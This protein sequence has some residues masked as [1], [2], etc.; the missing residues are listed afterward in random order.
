MPTP[1]HWTPEL[2]TRFWNGVAELPALEHV[3]FANLT[4]QRLV[5]L[6]RD[7]LK[8]DMT[9]LD[10]G[11]GSGHLV[12]ALIANGQRV[13]VFEPSEARAH[14][15]EEMFKNEPSFLGVHGADSTE[16]FDAVLCMEVI[17]HILDAD[18]AEFLRRM[19]AHVR[20]GGRLLLTTPYNEKL[21]ESEVYCPQCDSVFHR[22][23]HVRNFTATSLR[24]TLGAAG[25]EPDEIALV[26]F[27]DAEA[28]GAFVR[29]RANADWKG[30]HREDSGDAFANVGAA[31]HVFFA[32]RKTRA[33]EVTEIA[34]ALARLRGRRQPWRQSEQQHPAITPTTKAAG[35]RVDTDIYTPETYDDE[36]GWRYARSRVRADGRVA[37]AGANGAA[38]S[39]A[40]FD[41]EMGDLAAAPVQAQVRQAEEIHIRDGGTWRK[42]VRNPTA[43]P[44]APG[45]MRPM[46]ALRARI[47]NAVAPRL[48]HAPIGRRLQGRLDDSEIRLRELLTD[49]ADFPFR[50][51]HYVP[52]RIALGI[53]SLSSGGAERQTVYVASGLHARGHDDV[54]LVIDHLRDSAAHAFYLAKAAE[55]ARSI[56]EIANEDY[57]QLPWFAEH[58]DFWRILGGYV[59]HRVLNT[60]RHFHELAPE[61]VQT[62]LDWTNITMGLAAVMAGVPRVLVSGRNLSPTHFGFFQWFMYPAYRA[63]AAQ[64]NVTLFNNSESG[65]RDYEKWLGLPSGS[66]AVV[67][68]GI[69]TAA[70]TPPAPRTRARARAH[71]GLGQDVPVVAGAFRLSPEKRP[72]LWLKCAAA[73]VQRVPKVEFLLL[74][75]G[76]MQMK[77][78]M[79]AYK[80]GIGDR[81]KFAGV[82]KDIRFAFAAADAVLLTSLQEG[83]PN[84]LI[85]A[86]AMGLPVVSTP[87]FGAA[88]TVCDGVTGTI[89]PSA[90]A[91][92]LADATAA[93]LNDPGR[94]ARFSAAGPA[95]AAERFGMERMVDELLAL[96]ARTGV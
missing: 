26:G 30:Y 89:V 1:L 88:E 67:R 31:D 84:V 21:R 74:G 48:F 17:E 24:A 79:Y 29:S 44:T 5:E 8:P 13:A 62:S 59:A 83:T 7:F 70:F 50:S 14:T 54:H 15:A 36:T 40:V 71:F 86:Q 72:L 3:S 47:W 39:V 73:L 95:W 35:L 63:L 96:Q 12:K 25:F 68:N 20:L 22:W 43:P 85:E 33:P 19:N 55:T 27:N 41:G 9:C 2:I 56:H 66:V 78:Q 76:P 42:L 53:S 18:L 10:Y 92:D 34:A 75:A 37:P 80:L 94:A 81:V 49:T 11:G 93:I 64:P 57:T 69:D 28:L 45:P 61:V 6:M 38:A 4:S 23:Q 77:A 60:A 51:T 65:A 16:S 52:G 82:A 58:P 32:G 90:R 87:A 91:E 46:S